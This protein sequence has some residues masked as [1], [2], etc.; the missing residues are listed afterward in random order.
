M[1]D[2]HNGM[3]VRIAAQECCARVQ[4]CRARVKSAVRTCTY[5][6]AIASTVPTDATT[7]PTANQY[8]NWSAS[9]IKGAHQR[10]VGE[11]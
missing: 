9:F 3:K 6:R 8:A 4:E 1:S 11:L 7:V 10:A 2:W 5:W